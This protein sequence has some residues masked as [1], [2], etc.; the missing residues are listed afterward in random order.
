MGNDSQTLI[1]LIIPA[2]K[3]VEKFVCSISM[4]PLGYAVSPLTGGMAA[5]CECNAVK[6]TEG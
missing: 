5:R 3:K 1:I 4:T 2:N 6:R